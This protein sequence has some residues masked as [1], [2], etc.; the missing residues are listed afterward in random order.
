VRK[1]Q[2]KLQINRKLRRRP[3]L[4]QIRPHRLADNTRSIIK[5]YIDRLR[6]TIDKSNL[7]D[8]RKKAMHGRLDD[9]ADELEKRRLNLG[10]TMVA[11]SMV[12]MGLAANPTTIAADGPSA[13]T[14]IMALI[15]G[16]KESE[17][18][19][20]LRLAPPPKALPAPRQE[21]PAVKSQPAAAQ[22]IDDDIPF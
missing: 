21:P 13:I 9:L 1:D 20:L 12:M 7:S 8:A 22:V 17:D 16:D 14:H 10:K 15:G 2:T 18:A 4:D 5:H 3:L 11:L 19:A 6:D